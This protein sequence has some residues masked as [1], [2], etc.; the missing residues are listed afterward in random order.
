[1]IMM[2]II[3]TITF[4]IDQVKVQQQQH[5]IEDIAS[6]LQSIKMR[7]NRNLLDP[8]QLQRERTIILTIQ[9]TFYRAT[10]GVL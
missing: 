10:G 3:F 6:S 4:F 1:M 5:S 2:T 8:N 9:S 7:N